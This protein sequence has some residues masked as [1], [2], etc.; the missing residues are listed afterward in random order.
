MISAREGTFVESLPGLFPSHEVQ[1]SFRMTNQGL[2]VHEDKVN[3]I[4]NLYQ[5]WLKEKTQAD[6]VK[7]ADKCMKRLFGSEKPVDRSI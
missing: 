3:E 7:P 4:V 1:A 5:S 2:F 6:A